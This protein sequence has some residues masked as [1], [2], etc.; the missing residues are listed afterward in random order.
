MKLLIAAVAGGALVA[1][2]SPRKSPESIV[3]V[4]C[5]RQDEPKYEGTKS[6]QKCHFQ[7]YASWQKTAM[8]QAFKSL[9]PK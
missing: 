1:L 5:F 2:W 3:P 9:K 8:A 6:C 7:E 4:P